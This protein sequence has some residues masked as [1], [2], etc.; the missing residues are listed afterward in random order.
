VKALNS[1]QTNRA[2]LQELKKKERN[3]R[4]SGIK[5]FEETVMFL[6]RCVVVRTVYIKIIVE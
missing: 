6:E 5:K 2:L 1:L 3:S 4:A